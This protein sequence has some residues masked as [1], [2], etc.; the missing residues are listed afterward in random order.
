MKKMS[1]ISR[2]LIALMIPFVLTVNAQQALPDSELRLTLE[3]AVYHWQAGKATEAYLAL[4]SIIATPTAAD[5]AATKVKAALW[6]ANYLTA[7]KKILPA[8]RFLDSAMT[9]AEKFSTMEELRRTYE[10]YSEWHLAA[11]NP[12]TA[13]ISREAAWKISDSLQRETFIATIDSL[14]RLGLEAESENNRLKG[15][16]SAMQAVSTESESMKK[17]T[18]GLGGLCAV[19]LVLVFLLNGNLQRLRNAPPAPAARPVAPTARPGVRSST[20]PLPDPAP[21]VTDAAKPSAPAP[22]SKPAAP[23]SVT[24]GRDI[25]GRLREVEL[26]LISA[27][28]LG[29]HQNGET[30]AIRNLLNEYMAQL[31][32]IMKT[33]DEAITKNEASPILLSLEHLKPYIHSFGMQSTNRLIEEIETDAQSEKVSKLLSRVF[34]VRNHCRRAADEAKALL[35]KLN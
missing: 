16:I 29:Q 22:A 32:F 14:R 23:V 15:E 30:K 3:R 1:R 10:A 11:G 2:L 8:K 4:D 20:Q 13:I 21:I 12:K 31:P 17:W 35:E 9:W 28:T 5:N 24:P 7:Q 26:V 6:T 19:L 34:Q 33:L 27:D 18:Y 25:A